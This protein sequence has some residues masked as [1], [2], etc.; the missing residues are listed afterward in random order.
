MIWQKVTQEQVAKIAK[1]PS[2]STSFKSPVPKPLMIN[3]PQLPSAKKGS[4][5]TSASNQQPTDQSVDLKKKEAADKDVP[6][7]LNDPKKKF[8][9]STDLDPK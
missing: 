3:S 7:D 1:M 8:R 4:Y 6:V 5:D 9:V 2:G